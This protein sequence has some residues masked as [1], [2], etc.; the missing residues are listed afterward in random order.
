MWRILEGVNHENY[1]NQ[2][3]PG[4]VNLL[5]GL[6][7]TFDPY[8]DPLEYP[9]QLL[10]HFTAFNRKARKALKIKGFF[11]CHLRHLTATC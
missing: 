7:Y 2:Y 3:P 9:L 6:L 8:S 4:V 1:V 11:Y 5:Y 10:F